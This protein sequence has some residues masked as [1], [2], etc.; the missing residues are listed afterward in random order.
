[1]FAWRRLDPTI[2]AQVLFGAW[3]PDDGGRRASF[4]L[5]RSAAHAVPGMDADELGEHRRALRS[6]AQEGDCP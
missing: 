3:R 6:S 2:T 1:M 5:D 4:S